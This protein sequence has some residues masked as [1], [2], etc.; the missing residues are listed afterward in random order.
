MP[1][2]M[3]F[4]KGLLL[5]FTIFL[6]GC[7]STAHREAKSPKGANRE[8][9]DPSKEKP[10]LLLIS[11]DGYRYD[12]TERFHPPNLSRFISEG[13]QAK[14]LIPCFPSKTFPNHYSIATGMRPENHLLVDN[15]FYDR[16]KEKMYR[17][18]DRSVVEDGSWYGGSPIWVQASKAGM[19]TASYFFVGS[20][21]DIQ[22]IRPNYYYPYDGS[23]PNDERVRTVLE[24]LKLPE[25]QRPQMIAMYFSDMDDV[26]HRF[27][28]NNDEKLKAKLFEL[29]E[30]LGQLFAGVESSGL[31]VNIIIVSDHGMT[32][33][34]S[35]HLLSIERVRDDQRYITANNGALA[36]L[37]LKQGVNPSEVYEEL[38]AKK[39]H[40]E[41]YMTK[42]SPFYATNRSNP[43]LG[44][45]LV[46][47]EFGYYFSSARGIEKRKAAG[48]NVMGEHGFSPEHKDLHG[49]FYAQ[50]PALKKGLTIESFENIHIYPLLCEIL[51]LDIPTEIDGDPKVLESV[52]LKKDDY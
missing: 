41:V 34:K 46:V 42:N 31:P 35:E 13:V 21:A 45:L 18:S 48:Q 28:P 50:G 11:L 33:I 39:E 2:G 44:E 30:V 16:K 10:Y 27:G 8:L 43:L 5:I 52:L 49:I 51:G 4:F 6:F 38:S 40:F 47:P 24:W 7:N 22:G 20:E 1:N 17:I 37:Y 3:N 32:E 12:Y 19:V 14:S 26:G 25:N 23:V 29:D 36:H 15:T 9:A